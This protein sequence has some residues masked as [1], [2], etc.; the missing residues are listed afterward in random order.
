MTKT[1][2]NNTRGRKTAMS[3]EAKDGRAGIADAMARI[4]GKQVPQGAGTAILSARWGCIFRSLSKQKHS[5]RLL[6]Y[7]FYFY[8]SDCI[9][10]QQNENIENHW[11]VKTSH[12]NIQFVQAVLN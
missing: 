4:L 11:F 12:P 10:H 2:K 3:V 9:V 5:M 7:W 8:R 6:K 1:K